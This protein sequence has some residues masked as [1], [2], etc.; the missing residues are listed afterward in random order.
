MFTSRA[1]HRLLLREDN[2]DRRLTPLGRRLG[3]VDD[4]RWRR[5]EAKER[6]VRRLLDELSQRSVRPDA[7]SRE[8]AAS[9]G[10]T[11]PPR[12]ASLADLL[13]QPE[14]RI[15]DLVV[16]WPEIGDFP[17]DVLEEAE[18]EAKYA[19]YLARQEE[20]V[21]R[22]A[23]WETTLLPEDLDYG[24]I[25]GLSREVVEKLT[26]IRPRTLG[27]ASRISGVTPAALACVEIALA[28]RRR[29]EQSAP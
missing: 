23:L 4:E 21:A 27:Q 22:S 11:L 25:P 19:G 18:T 6:S 8:R 14:A 24:A 17:A 20:L 3:L 15:T 9:V 13:R 12:A 26:R 1:E 28:K 16:F 7:A 5:F 2:A 29:H 10:I